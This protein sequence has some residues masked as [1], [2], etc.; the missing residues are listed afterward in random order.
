MSH[1]KLSQDPSFSSFF[2]FVAVR[3]T[4]KEKTKVRIDFCLKLS[5]PDQLALDS[6]WKLCKVNNWVSFKLLSG[7]LRM[8]QRKKEHYCLSIPV[9]EY[10]NFFFSCHVNEK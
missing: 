10:K 6:V 3:K 4:D 1:S 8:D 2:A 5:F 7:H 9:E